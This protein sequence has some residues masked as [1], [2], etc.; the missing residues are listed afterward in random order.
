MSKCLDQCLSGFR[1]LYNEDHGGGVGRHEIIGRGHWSKPKLSA[2]L[3]PT[4]QC[5]DSKVGGQADESPRPEDG[6]VNKDNRV[7]VLEKWDIKTCLIPS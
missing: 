6:L 1:S 2:T 7:L 3:I 5:R 4:I